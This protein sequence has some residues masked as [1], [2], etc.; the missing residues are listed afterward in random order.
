MLYG[1]EAAERPRWL[2]TRVSE[3]LAE[4]VKA[5]AGYTGVLSH[6]P[7]V[8]DPAQ[9]LRTEWRRKRPYPLLE[10]AEVI[11]FGWRSPVV[12][13]TATGRN[14]AMFRYFPL[15]TPVA[16]GP[17]AANFVYIDPGMET[18]SELDSWGGAHRRLWEK[19][20][21]SGR[22]VEVVAVAREQELLD[23][24]GR[25]L[26]SWVARDMS[27][28]EK[29]ALMLHQAIA[30][31]DWQAV[32]RHGGLD[33]VM[34]KTDQWEQENPTSNCR[35]MI[36]DFRLRGSRTWRRMG[37]PLTRGG[38]RTEVAHGVAHDFDN[39]KSALS[40]GEALAV[41]VQA[42]PGNPHWKRVGTD[43]PN[44]LG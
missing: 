8:P 39:Y 27:K 26:Q 29:E 36:D 4:V 31:A 21:K 12:P 42:V 5:D 11:P 30:E 15:K 2:L 23:R 33:V 3:Y 41:V 37:G 34:E 6:N 32:E 35:E 17:E 18:R 22:R 43:S 10:L 24:A 38:W 9:N 7:M 1:P 25:R 20:R 14:E 19:L 13:K 44:P 16:V 28:G 40:E